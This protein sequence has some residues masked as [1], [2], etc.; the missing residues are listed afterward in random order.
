MDFSALRALA[1]DLNLSAHGVDVM[2]TPPGQIAVTGRGIWMTPSRRTASDEVHEVHD[3][4]RRDQDRGVMALPR[5]Q[6]PSVPLGTVVTAPEQQ[7]GT[8]ADWRVDGI[9]RVEAD[10]LRAV[11]VPA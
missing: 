6:F 3:F 4:T 8:P 10:H 11:L 9:E 1:L 2:V 7:G 5:S